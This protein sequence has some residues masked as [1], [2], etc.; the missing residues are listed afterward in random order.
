MSE[1]K[2]KLMPFKLPLWFREGLEEAK[3]PTN[4]RKA[5]TVA[6]I[7][8]KAVCKVEKIK[9]PKSHKFRKPPEG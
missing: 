6:E 9:R 8:I 7:V 2:T 1:N 3:K 4:K 5:R